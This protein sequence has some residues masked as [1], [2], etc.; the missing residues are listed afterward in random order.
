MGRRSDRTVREPGMGP[1]EHPEVSA[2][3]PAQ[4]AAHWLLLSPLNGKPSG[5]DFL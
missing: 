4:A 3:V 5:C 1:R 2:L